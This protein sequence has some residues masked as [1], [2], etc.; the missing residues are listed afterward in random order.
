MDDN[1][2]TPTP[3]YGWIIDKDFIDGT[4]AGIM[5]PSDI[6]PLIR[7]KLLSGQ[8]RKFRMLD[9]DGEVYY[10]GRVIGDLD[11]GGDPLTD[12]GGPNAGC[13]LYEERIDGCWETVIG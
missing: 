1:T 10:N 5:G 13:T 6:S 3:S 7:V 2:D 12:F 8:G 9:D 11:D 4:D